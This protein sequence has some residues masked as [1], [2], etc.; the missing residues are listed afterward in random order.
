[1]GKLIMSG[2]AKRSVEADMETITVRF[3]TV[4][5]SSTKAAKRIMDDCESFLSIIKELGV[6]ISRIQLKGDDIDQDRY[7]E[8]INIKVTA[9]RELK[10]TLEYDVKFNNDIMEMIQNNDWN[11]DI[12]VEHFISNKEEIH[13]ELLAKAV[14]DSRAKAEII[15]SASGQKIVGIDEMRSGY[16]SLEDMYYMRG[17]S[18]MELGSLPRKPLLSDQLK[19]AVLD[20]EETVTITWLV[21]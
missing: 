11:V 16:H 18:N 13:K 12:G 3:E 20:E 17:E 8:N 19:A 10:I 2:A 7:E 15:V 4:E 9:T 5:S 6:D 1:M 21:E 14:E